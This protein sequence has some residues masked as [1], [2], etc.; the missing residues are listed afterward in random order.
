MFAGYSLEIDPFGIAAPKIL[1]GLEWKGVK[2]AKNGGGAD[3][4]EYQVNSDIN[5]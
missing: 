4:P 2:Y 5:S 1:E 3:F